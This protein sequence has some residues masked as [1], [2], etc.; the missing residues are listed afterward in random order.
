MNKFLS[1]MFAAMLLTVA[2]LPAAASPPEPA[3][4][5]VTQN[6]SCWLPN[7]NL[8]PTNVLGAKQTFDWVAPLHLEAV[9]QGQ[10]P[11]DAPRPKETVKV[12]YETTGFVCEITYGRMTYRTA[13][14]GAT[15]HPDGT[16]E[17]A[18]LVSLE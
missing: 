1:I 15:V 13:E 9:C 10:L 5:S 4:Y 2:F 14:Y 8:K 3:Y 6:G 11:K 7:A 18:C 17:I 16:T 12:T